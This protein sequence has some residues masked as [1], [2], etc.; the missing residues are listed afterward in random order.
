LAFL[1][2]F[3]LYGLFPYCIYEGTARQASPG[4]LIALCLIPAVAAFRSRAD[5]YV[6]LS[7]EAALAALTFAI[8]PACVPFVGIAGAVA[9]LVF[10][11]RAK[12]ALGLGLVHIA[13]MLSLSTAL[14]F[15]LVMI[16]DTFYQSVINRS[17]SA[18]KPPARGDGAR[19][20]SPQ[21]YI[22]RVRGADPF[23]FLPMTL[24][25]ELG[26]LGRFNGWGRKLPQ[27]LFPRLA[28]GLSLLASACWLFQW[29]RGQNQSAWSVGCVVAACLMLWLVL[30]YPISIIQRSI[31]PSSWQLY[32]LR[33]YTGVLRFRYELVV[34]FTAL[35]AST[36][37]LYLAFPL[38]RRGLRLEASVSGV[39]PVLAATVAWEL[40]DWTDSGF[41][42]Q[43][44]M[45]LVFA[46][47]LLIGIV[48]AVRVRRSHRVE[49]GQ[50]TRWA[51]G[52]LIY[53][54]PFALVIWDPSPAGLITL[55]EYP[56]GSPSVTAQDV[57][58][59]KWMDEHIS[60]DESLIAL[61]P[62]TW[63]APPP[64]PQRYFHPIG[65]SQALF[66]YSKHYNYCFCPDDPV[67]AD[68]YEEYTQHV[69]KKL[70][71]DWCLKH[72]I[73]YFF[74]AAGALV[75]SPGPAEA[76]ADGRLKPVRELSTCALYELAAR[77]GAGNLT[78]QIR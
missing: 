12:P 72:K 1:S 22:P 31:E 44:E 43:A 14:A 78:G 42:V 49:F 62:R 3:P 29:Q 7:T 21:K 47:A 50:M 63:R 13:A 74:V 52:A 56:N 6:L 75:Y 69:E 25:S 4:I 60:P 67:F 34:F 18:S 46:V 16:S 61:T 54:V 26:P 8:N 48:A 51:M 36:V 19:A 68:S 11:R 57:E 66:L 58:L 39:L 32:L 24:D 65:A 77:P 53:L 37:Y 15:G 76:I 27:W 70:D 9:T 38:G 33:T 64:D 30:G 71:V 10:W 45:A 73:H 28:I 23:D 55:Q 5:L 2:L 40:P 59:V 20:A 17:V 41:L 35:L